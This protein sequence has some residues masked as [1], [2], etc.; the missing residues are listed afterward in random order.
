VARQNG[1]IDLLQRAEHIYDIPDVDFVSLAAD[2]LEQAFGRPYDGTFNQSMAPLLVA[3]RKQ[4]DSGTIAIP[5]KI[6]AHA[7]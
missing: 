1:I 4:L 6:T 2:H 3:Y 5:G 7:G